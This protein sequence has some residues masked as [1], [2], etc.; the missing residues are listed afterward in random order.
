MTHPRGA[1]MPAE[2]RR[3]LYLALQDPH[4]P[5]NG[6]CLRGGEMLRRLSREFE[7]DL[8]YME[9]AGQ[10]PL[11]YG[12]DTLKNLPHLVERVKV[13]F[14]PSAYFL[15]SRSFLT[16]A[17]NLLDRR[18]HDFIVC[19]YGIC[20][21]YGLILSRR[22]GLRFIYSSHNLEYR[23]NLNKSRE[24]LRRL[25]LALYMYIVERL[26]V[27]RAESVVAITESDAQ[28]YARWTDAAKILVIPQGIDE[29]IFNPYY[30][31]PRNQQKTVLF[32]GNFKSQFNRN[33]VAEVK[34]SIADYV[35]ARVPGVRFKFVGAY[36]PMDIKHPSFEYTGFADDYVEQLKAADVVISPIMQ[37]QGFPTKIIEAL[38]VGKTVI[39]TP[40]GA[41]G[42]DSSLGSLRI[43]PLE[44]FPQA[45]VEAL[46][47]GNGVQTEDFER[48]R[49]LYSWE[50]LISRLVVRMRGSR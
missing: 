18:K 22:A 39:S 7:T 3:L 44:A 45:I 38:A 16:A 35:V 8:V 42:V 6:T 21:L 36:P 41:R 11:P 48:V 47:Q 2:R 13:P 23:G 10:P 9:G 12:E 24:D 14:S 40:V 33:A 5:V 34:R 37:G 32:C 20:A 29:S 1:D 27:Q 46:T 4:L 19:D 28:A 17:R 26:G 31:A 50:E 30:E 43:R 49:A 15:F 25:P